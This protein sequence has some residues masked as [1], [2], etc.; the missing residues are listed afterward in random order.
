MIDERVRGLIGDVPRGRF[1]GPCS[2]GDLA[3]AFLI[4]G[5]SVDRFT[6]C[7]LGYKGPRVTA[8]EAVPADW[9]LI[10]R[11]QGTDAAA[12]EKVTWYSGDRPFR[13]SATI[14]VWRRPDES[15]VIVELR[16]DLA[17]DVLMGHFPPVSMAAFLHVNDGTGE[18]GSDLW[19]L[20]TPGDNDDRLDRSIRLLPAVASRLVHGAIVVTDGG[21][22][23]H[24]FRVDASFER[25][26][27]RWEPV[28]ELPN[29]K[30]PC[31]PMLVWRVL[32]LRYV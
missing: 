14:E 20:A 28:T 4:F 2:G 7:D 11:V 17:Q 25:A 8:Q 15:E 22:T 10:S 32:D 3:V 19:F 12:S 27:R 30:S 6:F 21:L 26:G 24:D 29:S 18:G 23:D 5:A 16:R 31:R 13:P 1:Y 9:A